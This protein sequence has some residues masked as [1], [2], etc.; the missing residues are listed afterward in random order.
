MKYPI[1]YMDV[2]IFGKSPHW[3]DQCPRVTVVRHPRAAHL[4]VVKREYN[5]LTESS[6]K[7]VM[8]CQEYFMQWNAFNKGLH[9]MAHI[10][11]Y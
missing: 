1:A 6:F 3:D 10:S 11:K 4:D 2:R 5:Y 9:C 7:R 8:R